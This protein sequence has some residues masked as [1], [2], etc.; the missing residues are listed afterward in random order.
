MDIRLIVDDDGRL[1]AL[2]DSDSDVIEEASGRLEARCDERAQR[3]LAETAHTVQLNVAA[4]E[5]GQTTP[6]TTEREKRKVD[7]PDD[8]QR[9]SQ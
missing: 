7:S 8:G 9:H 3:D 1:V 6:D 4:L 2:D 5:A